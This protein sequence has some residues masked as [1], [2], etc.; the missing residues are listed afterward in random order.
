MRILRK[1]LAVMLVAG[2][3]VCSNGIVNAKA[4]ENYGIDLA[5]EFYFDDVIYVNYDVGGTSVDVIYYIHNNIGGIRFYATDYCDYYVDS[6]YSTDTWGFNY[7]FSG[8]AYETIDAEFENGDKKTSQPIVKV[9]V[10]SATICSPNDEFTF[11]DC[12]YIE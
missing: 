10:D 3:M 8:A 4:E 11:S 5:V 6:G 2:V 1:I 12:A 7:D 9:T